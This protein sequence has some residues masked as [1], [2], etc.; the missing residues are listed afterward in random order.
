[1]FWKDI[2]LGWFA[3]PVTIIGVVGIINAVNMLDGVD[4]LAASL[5]LMQLL[6]L[7]LLAYMVDN[8]EALRVLLI[9]CFA[10]SGFLFFNLRFALTHKIRV[11][12]GDAGS[13]FIGFS[14]SWFLVCLSQNPAHPISAVTMLWIMAIPL[15]DTLRVMIHRI[16]HKRSPFSPGRDHIHH[17]LEEKGYHPIQINLI[18]SMATLILGFFGIWGAV[19]HVAEGLMFMLFLGLFI[20]YYGFIRHGLACK[21]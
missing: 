20:L 9:L 7:S 5:G 8:F 15:F 2:Y 4:G 10:L 19:Y 12:M 13:M 3:I 6:L 1:M 21:A 11:F 14:L 16:K 17:F 18:L